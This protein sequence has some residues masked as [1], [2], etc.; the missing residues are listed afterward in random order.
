MRC[1]RL[2][3]ACQR[4]SRVDRRAIDGPHANCEPAS[5]V[6][7]LIL[8]QSRRCNG[9][10]SHERRGI[11]SASSQPP[12]GPTTK[13]SVPGPW[14]C[15]QLV[16]PDLSRSCSRAFHGSPFPFGPL[17]NCHQRQLDDWLPRGRSASRSIGR[18]RLPQFPEITLN[19]NQL[20]PSPLIHPS[21]DVRDSRLGRYTEVGERT[22]FVSS[23]LDDYSYIVEDGE[24]IYTTIGKFCSIAGCRASIPATPDGARQ[25]AHFTYRA[26]TYVEGERDERV[27][28][29]ARGASA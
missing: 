16:W 7:Q 20:G 9:F 5:Q 28:R 11:V 2:Q 6:A 22:S 17:P 26:S 23:T 14:P 19:G 3:L 15:G 27:L 4:L 29:L 10:F 8:R 18:S 13:N 24:V 21:A 25:Q 1:P 12:D